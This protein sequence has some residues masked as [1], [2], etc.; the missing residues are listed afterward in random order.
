MKKVNRLNEK[1][2]AIVGL[3]IIICGVIVFFS[4]K[5]MEG[6]PTIMEPTFGSIGFGILMII[7]GFIVA[8][9]G[10]KNLLSD[11]KLEEKDKIKD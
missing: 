7:S 6:D 5:P 3:I 11:K 4:G 8:G 9:K 10:L 2:R 1:A